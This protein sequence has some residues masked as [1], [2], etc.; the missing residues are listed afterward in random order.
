MPHLVL[1]LAVVLRDGDGGPVHQAFVKLPERL[2]RFLPV[3]GGG[4]LITLE[5]VVRANVGALY[6]D[7]RILE[8]HLFRITRA[9]D[10]ELAE[11]RSGNLLQAIEEAVGRRA[12]NA[13]CRVEVERTMPQAVR[14]RL[15][16]ELRFE[17][18][19]DAGSLGERDVFPVA[20]PLDLRGLREL[21]DAPVPGGRFPPFEGADPFPPGQDLWHLIAGGERLVHHPYDRFDRSV[22]RFFA[23]AADDPAVVG[24]RATLYRVGERSTLVDSLLAALRRGKDVSIFVELKARFDE[25]RNAGWVRRL[26]EAGANVA[27]GVVG[28]KN[29]AKL[30]L[31]VRG[32]GTD[33]P[34]Y[35]RLS[36]RN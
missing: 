18:G 5:E 35:R 9:A 29:H 2:P 27:Y 28:L 1:L 3:T 26:E 17:P 13:V 25:S 36:E 31:V 7:R 11:D 33:I 34:R 8:A 6:P 12:A 15:L 10:L 14:D 23:D 24:I 22:G 19:A 4:D 20:G 21:L 32:V 16:W 30:A